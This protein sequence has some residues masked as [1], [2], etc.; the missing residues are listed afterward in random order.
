[1]SVVLEDTLVELG[2]NPESII[3]NRPGHGVLGI[4]AKDVRAEAQRI[5]RSPLTVEL[6]HGDVWGEK[7]GSRRR[8]LATKAFWVVEPPVS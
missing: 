3:E 5:E 7:P 1:M 8:R 6:A 4:R 2:R